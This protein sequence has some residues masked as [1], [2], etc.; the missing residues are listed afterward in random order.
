MEFTRLA[1]FTKE[2]RYYDAIARITDLFEEWQNSTR[3]PGMWPTILDASGC[4][5]PTYNKPVSM[6]QSPGAAQPVVQPPAGMQLGVPYSPNSRPAK[7]EEVAKPKESI[8]VNMS[9]KPDLDETGHLRYPKI[10]EAKEDDPGMVTLQ[11]PDPIVFK[12]D[13]ATKSKQ[14]KRQLDEVPL[15]EKEKPKDPGCDYQGFASTSQFGSEQFTLGGMSDSMYEYLPKEWLLLGGLV[16]QYKTMYEK[17]ADAAIKHLVYR[18][19]TPTDED[20]LYSGQ[21]NMGEDWS[22]AR[23]DYENAH[24]TCFAGGMFAMGAK[25]FEREKDLDIGRK[26]AEGCV[27]AYNV[28]ASGIM[29]ESYQTVPCDDIK[30]CTWNETKWW[31]QLDPY[32]ENRMKTYDDQMK[33]YSSQVADFMAE[34]TAKAQRAKEQAAAAAAAAQAVVTDASAPLQTPAAAANHQHKRQLDDTV[35]SPTQT[36]PKAAEPREEAEMKLPPSI[37]KPI[38]PLTHKE[39]VQQRIQEERLPPGFTHVGGRKYILR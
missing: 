37:W 5:K 29:P 22:T 27:Y 24:L 26:L 31:R 11:K 33:L 19:M 38:M 7:A 20:I 36:K 13:D 2:P 23:F 34:E 14:Q 6:S 17:S 39:R 1:Q 18:P 10:D 4:S 21:L 25:I 30:S 16:D 35:E 32:P 3:V 9:D 15:A 8:V 28:T 12:N